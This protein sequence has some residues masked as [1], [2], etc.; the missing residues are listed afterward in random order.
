MWHLS[1]VGVLFFLFIIVVIICCLA[2]YG[3]EV[4]SVPSNNSSIPELDYAT[5]YLSNLVRKKSKD[6]GNVALKF[7]AV[8][9]DF[10]E[11]LDIAGKKEL[12]KRQ[13]LRRPD[14]PY[15][16]LSASSE[17]WGLI[18]DSSTVDCS[19]SLCQYASTELC[20]LNQGN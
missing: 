7:S 10:I 16:Y 6:I 15:H 13:N 12:T 17:M 1:I 3:I 2:F 18:L 8:T 14:S 4:F 19:P 9:C 20:E 11:V 5:C